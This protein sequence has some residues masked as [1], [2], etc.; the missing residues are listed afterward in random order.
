[1]LTVDISLPDIDELKALVQE[2]QEKGYLTFD[3]VEK[4]LSA[5]D[6]TS[7]I[8]ARDTAMIELLYATG[9]RV[10]ELCQLQGTDIDS[11]RMVINVRQGKGQRDRGCCGN[12]Q[13]AIF[14]RGRDDHSNFSIR[15]PNSPR[16]RTSSTRNI[17]T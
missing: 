5:P 16:G 8:G 1:M 15:S 7:A 2:G 17:R 14:L 9:L 6:R 3:E 4:L 12:Q 11:Q 10:S 13:R